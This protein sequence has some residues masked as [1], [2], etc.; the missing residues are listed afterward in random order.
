M[1]LEAGTNRTRQYQAHHVST[2]YTT[3]VPGTPR[4]HRAH[5]V[6]TRL[7]TRQHQAHTTSAPGSQHVSTRHTSSAP[8]TLHVSTR[9]T[10]SQHQAHLHVSTAALLINTRHMRVALTHNA[11]FIVEKG[12]S[13]VCLNNKTRVMCST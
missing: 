12:R 3:S 8:G 4:Q 10:T 1:Q 9:H 2:R 7:T 13:N 11:R 6:S 5:H